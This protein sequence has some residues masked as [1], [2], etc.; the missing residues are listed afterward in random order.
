MRDLRRYAHQTNVRVIFGGILILFIIGDGL[1]YLFYGKGAAILGFMCLIV[2]LSPLL[3]I[4]MF[5]VLMDW[6]VKLNI[7]LDKADNGKSRKD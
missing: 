4:G 3:L 2:G 5:F 1:I 7:R 6:V